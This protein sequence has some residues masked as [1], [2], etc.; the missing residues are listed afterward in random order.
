VRRAVLLDA[1]GTLLELE[2]PA[3]RL[4]RIL[5]E[6]H[7]IAVDV[8][9]ARRAL[10]AEIA[11]YRA[12][13]NEGTGVDSVAALRGRCAEVLRGALVPEAP[14]VARLGSAEMTSALLD[15]L[16]FRAFPEV[17][18]ALRAIRAAGARAVVVSNWDASLEAVL[19][20]IG[21]R[22]ELDVVVS[23]GAYGAAKP[24]P[25][26][27]AEGLRRVGAE[28][29]QALHVGDSIYEDVAGARAAGIEP[30]L[31]LRDGHRS[32]PQLADE[33]SEGIRTIGSLSEVVGLIDEPAGTSVGPVPEP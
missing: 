8:D 25:A 18:P 24:D 29:D 16:V 30:V 15:S 12:H 17:R 11:Y 33:S 1:Y 26:I 20:A 21:L 3:P 31:L 28:P 19:V 6:R 9:C 5:A 27:F 23:S 4:A 22:A 7:G 14:A 2:P 10:S 32:A 13:M